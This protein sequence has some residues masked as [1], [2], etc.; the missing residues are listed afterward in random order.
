M[1]HFDC[2]NRNFFGDVRM[3]TT[4]RLAAMVFAA[5]VSAGV[6]QAANLFEITGLTGPTSDGTVL[7]N[8]K[9]F[10]LSISYDNSTSSTASVLNSTLT[11]DTNAGLKTFVFGAGSSG[12]LSLTANDPTVLQINIGYVNAGAGAGQPI[13]GTLAFNVTG[14]S[15]L[16][17]NLLTAANVGQIV[18]A[19]NSYSG[20]LNGVILSGVGGVGNTSFNGTLAVPEPGSIGLLAGLGL[21]CGRRV[22]RRRQ[23]KQAAAV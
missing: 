3:R 2:E 23:Q 6:G 18:Q 8:G 22:W 5:V 20:T 19:G 4:L 21:V 10:S 15:K 17:N 11:V 16:S 7:Q 14:A 9:S 1:V 12:T 13:V